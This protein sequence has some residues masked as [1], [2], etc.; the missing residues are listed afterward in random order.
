LYRRMTVSSSQF[1][2]ALANRQYFDL[3]QHY[4]EVSI[5]ALQTY[6]D[7]QLRWS[8]REQSASRS[9]RGMMTYMC[10]FAIFVVPQLLHLRPSNQ[11]LFSLI[12]EK[13]DESNYN[14]FSQGYSP[15][16]CGNENN[17]SAQ[18]LVGGANHKVNS[19]G[20]SASGELLREFTSFLHHPEFIAGEPSQ[21]SVSHHMSADV[22]Q[23]VRDAVRSLSEMRPPSGFTLYPDGVM[24][25]PNDV[26]S[27][28]SSSSTLSSADNVELENLS[29]DPR[30]S[31]GP[32]IFDGD[33]A[34]ATP[35]FGTSVGGGVGTALHAVAALDHPLTLALLL[36]MGVDARSCHTAFRRYVQHEA[37][38]NG[39]INCLTLL[40]ELG[41]S[42]AEEQANQR[43]SASFQRIL[44]YEKKPAARSPESV[45]DVPSIPRHPADSPFGKLSSL[46]SKPLQQRRK[47][48]VSSDLTEA[49]GDTLSLLRLFASLVSQVS[50][51]SLTELDASRTLLQRAKLSEQTRAALAIQAG[52]TLPFDTSRMSSVP[53]NRRSSNLYSSDGHGNT[54]L[55]WAAF[56]NESTC[57]SLLLN[58]QVDPNARAYP[59]GWTPLHDAAYS[60]GHEVIALLIDA[61]AFVDARASSGATPLCFAAQEDAAEAAELLLRRGADLCTRCASEPVIS[62]DGSSNESSI[63][64]S[65]PQT[66]FSGYTPL[67]YCS[68]Y[69]AS[70][71]AK[72]LLQHHSAVSAMEIR[73]FND[74]L[75]IHVAVARGSSDVLRELL[76]A[77]ARV[78]TRSLNRHHSCS[79][80]SP[81]RRSNRRMENS[82]RSTVSD[83]A[84]SAPTTP[85]RTINNDSTEFTESLILPGTPVASSRNQSRGRSRSASTTSTPVSSPVLRSMIP[86][87]PVQSSKPW[88]C[89]TQRSIDECRQLISEVE[90][91]WTPNRHSLFT[92]AD[93]R[94]VAELLRVGKRL[95]SEGSLLF[96]DLWPEVLGFCGRGW[97]EVDDHDDTEATD[98]DCFDDTTVTE[99]SDHDLSLPTFN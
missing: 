84:L 80:A 70:K 60:N 41:N 47:A 73:D 89:L 34:N 15:P 17:R 22:E 2:H 23:V 30:R 26:T 77:G 92:P 83:S 79:S 28:A 57:V 43:D 7:M 31:S 8:H 95:E 75:P 3:I 19:K 21:C 16:R 94:A 62:N 36:A 86:A 13:F 67:H 14:P 1:Y 53:F 5:S 65:P 93:R 81:T 90:Q 51:G 59:S 29:L 74:R 58:Y 52:F 11:S 61:G 25:Q 99:S 91:N 9:G 78:E 20:L 54:P 55:H 48:D 45:V 35:N 38:C 10:I 49:F 87:Q 50:E 69:N 32:P 85:M 68:H 71:A 63:R 4:G 88:N 76:Q 37:A 44:S 42:F 40:L 27:A 12:E 97:F 98:M 72:V 24:I 64:P 82:S 6:Q 46:H 56:K 18:F 33:I 66:R 96:L 39:S